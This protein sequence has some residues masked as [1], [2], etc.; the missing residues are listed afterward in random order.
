MRALPTIAML[1]AELGPIERLPPFGHQWRR[2]A[3]V[4]RSSNDRPRW[5]SPLS[6]PLIVGAATF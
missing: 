2:P 4:H 1:L 3:P 6:R 5:I